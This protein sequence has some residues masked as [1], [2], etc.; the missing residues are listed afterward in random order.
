MG[1]APKTSSRSRGSEA[2]GARAPHLSAAYPSTIIRYKG[3]KTISWAGLPPSLYSEL[4]SRG[5]PA[6]G[7]CEVVRLGAISAHIQQKFLQNSPTGCRGRAFPNQRDKTPHL[8][9]MQPIT[10]EGYD[11]YKRRAGG[12]GGEMGRA[13]GQPTTC[14]RG[15]LAPHLAISPASR[16]RTP[17]R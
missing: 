1:G 13:R 4:P 16:Q 3:G 11:P 15:G 6:P 5:T 17:R 14:A 12:R 8:P 7:R 2:A 9:C 10:V